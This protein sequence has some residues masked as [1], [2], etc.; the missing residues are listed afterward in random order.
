MLSVMLFCVDFLVFLE[1]LRTLESFLTDLKNKMRLVIV[2]GAKHG[3]LH[4][5]HEV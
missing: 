2:E 3:D 5:I 4:R 1:I